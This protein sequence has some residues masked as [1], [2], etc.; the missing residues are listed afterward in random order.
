[1][2]YMLHLNFYKK[3]HQQNIKEKIK[4]VMSKRL[5]RFCYSTTLVFHKHQNSHVAYPVTPTEN[6]NHTQGQYHCVWFEF[7]AGV[8][9]PSS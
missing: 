3:L 5:T 9:V 6:S 4:M 8:F 1:M 2:L 7:S